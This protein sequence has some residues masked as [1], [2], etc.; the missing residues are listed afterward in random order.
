MPAPGGRGP[1]RD[2]GCERSCAAA[3]SVIRA[4]GPLPLFPLGSPVPTR[5]PPRRAGAPRGGSENLNRNYTVPRDRAGLTPREGYIEASSG[6][7]ALGIALPCSLSTRRRR[8][9]AKVSSP[10]ASPGGDDLGLLLSASSDGCASCSCPRRL[11]VAPLTQAGRALATLGIAGGDASRSE[12][13]AE[14]A[15]VPAHP[16]PAVP[17]RRPDQSASTGPGRGDRGAGD[18]DHTTTAAG[19]IRTRTSTPSVTVGRRSRSG[20]ARTTSHRLRLLLEPP[21][22][23]PLALRRSRRRAGAAPSDPV[24]S[25]PRPCHQGALW[26]APPP[27]SCSRGG[28][29]GVKRPWEGPADLA[30]PTPSCGSRPDRETDCNRRRQG[31]TGRLDHPPPPRRLVSHRR[32]VFRAGPLDPR[33]NGTPVERGG[34]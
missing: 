34:P 8:L 3:S 9:G 10:R 20:A 29:R 17:P 27:T 16:S 11:H 2:R 14:L 15:V 7:A 24:P 13:P 21:A 33:I 5:C 22:V 1:F 30:F 6:A 23:D 4:G 26:S 25:K 28:S 31:K 18:A 12:P 32:R 19:V